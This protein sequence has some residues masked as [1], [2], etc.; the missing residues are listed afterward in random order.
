MKWA[1]CWKPFYYIFFAVVLKTKC[2][3]GSDKTLYRHRSSE[4]QWVEL[5]SVI[6]LLW[7][8]IMIRGFAFPVEWMYTPHRLEALIAWTWTNP[9]SKNQWLTATSCACWKLSSASI[10]TYEVTFSILFIPSKQPNR[11]SFPR[12][13]HSFLPL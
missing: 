4:K 11:L 2:V 8:L 9:A 5:D 10:G 1:Q 7:D 12:P 13:M 6:N 3:S